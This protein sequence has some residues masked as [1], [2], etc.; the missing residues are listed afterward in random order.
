[1]DEKIKERIHK[2]LALSDSP[3]ENEAKL[4]MLRVRE[5][6]AKYNL[7]EK[8]ITAPG[9][10][11][12]FNDHIGVI[13]TAR[14]TAWKQALCAVIADAYRCAAYADRVEGSYSYDL[15][16]IGLKADFKVCK[17]A[18]LFAI[19]CVEDNVDKLCATSRISAKT[20]T[21]IANNYGYGFAEGLQYAFDAQTKRNQQEWGLIMALP[22]AV[23]DCVDQI[24]GR[25]R[26]NRAPAMEDELAKLCREKGI[27]DGYKHGQTKHLAESNPA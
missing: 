16:I 6:M 10:I 17:Q 11:E 9:P 19:H 21:S 20:R 26:K 25:T 4:A 12:V 18:V 3:N 13:Y 14:K 22:Q 5:L 7:S 1:M 8:D 23:N 2:L 27:R 15:G 24:C